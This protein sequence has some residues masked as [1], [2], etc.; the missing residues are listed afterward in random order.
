MVRSGGG[1]LQEMLVRRSRSLLKKLMLRLA[2]DAELEVMR[3]SRCDG[4]QQRVVSGRGVAQK[5]VVC[6]GAGDTLQQR[7]MGRCGDIQQERMMRGRGGLLQ[8]VLLR[9]CMDREQ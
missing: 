1:A 7:V 9:L 8:Q 6:G 2:V 4:L 3:G 5:Q